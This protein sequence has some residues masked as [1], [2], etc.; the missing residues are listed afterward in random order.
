[1][2]RDTAA[3]TKAAQR[4]AA[5]GV[6][7][8]T[9]AIGDAGVRHVIASLE[10]LETHGIRHRIEHLETM[11]RELVERLVRSRIVASM[12]PSHLGY[13]KA[14]QTDEWSV[15]AWPERADRAW[16]CRDIRDAGGVLVLGSDWPIAEYDA[17]QVLGYARL[18]RRPNCT[19]APIAP[20]QA[21]TG[22]MALEGMTSH[23]AIAD[24]T[25]QH[26]GRVAVG[27]RADLTGFAIDPV[28]S[29][30]DEVAQG[31]IRLTVSAGLVTHRDV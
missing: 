20:E 29:P 28:I 13:S 14:D 21:L 15:P 7:T 31:P 5:A 11:P 16:A 2:W 1:M 27:C 9:H 12:Q 26:A 17:R 30:A 18:R 19:D 4:L 22:L 10:H 25:E 3:Y 24:G 8:V 23:S 6:Q